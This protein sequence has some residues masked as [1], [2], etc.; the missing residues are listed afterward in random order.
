MNDDLIPDD[1]DTPADPQA[2]AEFWIGLM[3]GI[4]VGMW[5]MA[6]MLALAG[7]PR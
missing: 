6:S 3:L 5:F 2:R 1:F 4:V 7:V